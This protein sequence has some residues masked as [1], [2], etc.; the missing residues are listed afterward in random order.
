MPLIDRRYAE[1]L[2]LIAS[3][4]NEVDSFQDELKEVVNLYKNG[5]EFKYFLDN[6]EIKI[7]T[8]KEIIKNIFSKSLKKEMVN[9]LLLLL[10][11]GRI[12]FLPGI[13]EE[14]VKLADIRRNMLNITIYSAANL[15]ESQINK[16]RDKYG[17]LYNASK[18]KATAKIDPSLI[19]GIKVKIGDKVIDGSLKGR[20]E[21]IREILMK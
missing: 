5:T 13:Y 19:G 2:E 15:D 21:S 4:N 3:K 9:F 10:D 12:K 6:P 14:F 17:K 20:F 11:K 8:K 16:L 18:V 7:D 1:A